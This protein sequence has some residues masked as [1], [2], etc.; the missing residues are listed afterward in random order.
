M[1]TDSTPTARSSR[2]CFSAAEASNWLRP[3]PHVFEEIHA[4]SLPRFA[5]RRRYRYRRTKSGNTG[6]T[7]ADD[8]RQSAPVRPLCGP[9]EC[10]ND[11]WRPPCRR[12]KAGNVKRKNTGYH[13]SFLFGRINVMGRNDVVQKGILSTMIE[14]ESGRTN[15]VY[16]KSDENAIHGHAFQL[17]TDPRKT[18][19]G[20][21]HLK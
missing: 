8:R 11:P 9:F 1:P 7:S 13:L 10:R 14:N 6:A 15:W 20:A 5:D 19:Q 16:L 21:R 18:S 12:G 4:L 3:Y 2:C 17:P